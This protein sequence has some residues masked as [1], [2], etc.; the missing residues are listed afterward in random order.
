[1]IK[2]SHSSSVARSMVEKKAS[3]DEICLY[4]VGTKFRGIT[5]NHKLSDDQVLKMIALLDEVSPKGVLTEF[6]EEIRKSLKK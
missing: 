5:G 4:V 2:F 1:M 6:T 3:V